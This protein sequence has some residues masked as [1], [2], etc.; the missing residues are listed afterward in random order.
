M[1]KL[2]REDSGLVFELK[3]PFNEKFFNDLKSTINDFMKI[4]KKSFSYD[5]GQVEE[6]S[7]QEIEQFE[8]IIS[9][10][11][12]GNCSLQITKA[13]DEILSKLPKHTEFMQDS[14]GDSMSSDHFMIESDVLDNKDM[15]ILNLAGEFMEPYS[16]EEFKNKSFEI[17]ERC[18]SII[19]DCQELTHISTLAVGG[20][21]FLKSHCDSIGKKVA[22]CNVAPSIHSTLQMSGILHI[23]PV[24]DNLESAKKALA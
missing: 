21:V 18:N 3:P 23:I 15:A 2:K 13:S 1:L 8:E 9:I 11:K 10:L 6:L 20:F 7:I 14:K 19:L 17:M 5:F 16:L 24:E 22:L 12:N 4:G